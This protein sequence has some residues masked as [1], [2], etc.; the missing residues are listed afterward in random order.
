[1][2]RCVTGFGAIDS[3]SL[4]THAR[5]TLGVLLK[6]GGRT[7]SNGRLRVLLDPE[8]SSIAG[9]VENRPIRSRRRVLTEAVIDPGGS[10]IAGGFY[11]Q[12]TTRNTE[13]LHPVRCWTSPEC[14][15]IRPT[16]NGRGYSSSLR[17]TPAVRLT[18]ISTLQQLSRFNRND[19]SEPTKSG[20]P[21]PRTTPH[22]WVFSCICPDFVKLGSTFA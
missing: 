11:Q 19:S 13:G 3:R 22:I 7:E 20:K 9:F 10:L 6:V 15:S 18:E 2:T 8:I 12:A 1:M 16:T 5:H 21:K 14:R 4:A 17:S